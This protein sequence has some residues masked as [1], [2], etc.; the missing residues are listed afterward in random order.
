MIDDKNEK[1]KVLE[2]KLNKHRFNK[3]EKENTIKT[4]KKPLKSSTKTETQKNS[5]KETKND[6][7]D[8]QIKSTVLKEQNLVLQKKVDELTRQLQEIE[9]N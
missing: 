1:I 4:D 7:I 5:F 2:E 6:A 9:Q 3:D 8:N